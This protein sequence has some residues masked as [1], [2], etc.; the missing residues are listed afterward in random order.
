MTSQY[1]LAFVILNLPFY[2][3]L[4]SIILE[5]CKNP[6]F[7]V[8]ILVG[9]RIRE[10]TKVG[11]SARASN[12]PEALQGHCKITEVDTIDELIDCVKC[13]DGVVSVVGRRYMLEELSEHI[14]NVPWFS[15]FDAYHS[16]AV[17]HYLYDASI[18]FFPTEFYL[19]LAIRNLR[20]YIPSHRLHSP[21]SQD[22]IDTAIRLL[23]CNSVIIGHTRLDGISHLDRREIRAE[24]GITDEDRVV[25]YIPDV[26]R[27]GYTGPDL[28][29]PWYFLI[30]CEDNVVM[31]L[32]N[33]CFRL[34]NVQAICD[35]VNPFMGEKATLRSLR[36]FC[37]NNDALLV[38]FPRRIKEFKTGTGIT[39]KELSTMDVILSERNY[40][41]QS[42]PKATKMA[43]LVVSGYR[44]ASSLEALGLQTSFVTIALPIRAISEV[45]HEWCNLYDNERANTQGAS[46]LID[47]EDFARDFQKSHLEDFE[48][49]P[50]AADDAIK[51]HIGT[52]DGKRSRCIVNRIKEYLHSNNA[53]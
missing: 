17:S 4:G 25:L 31:R 48:F 13:V 9:P 53:R 40:Y 39:D 26:F 11:Y 23:K 19:N 3:T 50:H 47:A 14:K 24:W 37:D 42:L 28:V 16:T 44:S 22:E 21:L 41:P 10:G 27:F 20:N 29:T 38:M 8:E 34:R 46:W 45:D 7:D 1:R 32:L 33:A 49:D 5:A 6:Q 15:V 35:A 43:D 12:V 30:W 18:S 2:R 52:T 36:K 51:K